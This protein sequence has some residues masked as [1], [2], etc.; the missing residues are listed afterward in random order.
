MRL[1]SSA[2]RFAP[3]TADSQCSFRERRR[4]GA[5]SFVSRGAGIGYRL[6]AIGY[7]S[8]PRS[9]ELCLHLIDPVA[10]AAKRFDQPMVTDQMAGPDDH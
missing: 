5:S 6:F 10:S 1:E 2:P 9:A 7:Y 3:R 8:A 4:G